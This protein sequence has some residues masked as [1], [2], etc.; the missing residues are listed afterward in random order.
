VNVAGLVV[1]LPVLASSCACLAPNFKPAPLPC[2]SVSRS[3]AL[4]VCEV[5][6]PLC[7]SPSIKSVLTEHKAALLLGKAVS[8]LAK[9]L[10][11]LQQ[12][13]AAEM[14]AA[15]S[16]PAP[17]AGPRVQQLGSEVQALSGLLLQLVGVLMDPEI[18]MNPWADRW[19]GPEECGDIGLL[20]S[21]THTCSH[22]I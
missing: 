15:G 22:M 5:L 18:S 13:L 16:G 3:F 1:R 10:P 17:V 21:P 2:C 11:D 9:P 6:L 20:L 14:S 8:V 7:S 12:L 4:Q 19:G